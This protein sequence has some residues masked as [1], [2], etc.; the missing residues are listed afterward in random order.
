MAEAPTDEEV[1]Y[2]VDTIANVV[3][4]EIGIE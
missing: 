4:D 3:R 1:N 2:Y